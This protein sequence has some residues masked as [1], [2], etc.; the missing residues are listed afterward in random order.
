MKRSYYKKTSV[1]ALA[2]LITASAS[3]G[4][5]A[6]PVSLSDAVNASYTTQT[7]GSSSPA[8]DTNSSGSEYDTEN[9]NEE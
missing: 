9:I 6:A 2:L 7:V 1:L 3:A 4:F 8:E 5:T